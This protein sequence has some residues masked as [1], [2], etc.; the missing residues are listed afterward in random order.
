MHAGASCKL[1]QSLRIYIPLA[2][3]QYL[4]CRRDR[5]F[6]NVPRAPASIPRPHNLGETVRCSRFAVGHVV[7]IECLAQKLHRIP[8]PALRNGY[9]LLH[10]FETIYMP[11]TY[12]TRGT[13]EKNGY[14]MRYQPRVY[15]MVGP[16][17]R[18]GTGFWS[19]SWLSFPKAW[20]V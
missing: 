6:P 3:R 20:E 14:G 19:F 2:T 9:R 10:G 1:S 17:S 18:I 7:T 15:R 12:N 11:C 4:E 16:R 13:N 5:R 8:I